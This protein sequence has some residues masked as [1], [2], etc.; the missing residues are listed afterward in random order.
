MADKL[1]LVLDTL[2]RNFRFTQWPKAAV[3][4]PFREAALIVDRFFE[5]KATI[6]AD[7][8][9]TREGKVAARAQ[10]GQVA[11]E[12]INKWHTPRVAGL[13]ADLGVHRAALLP[14]S[15]EKPDA[16]RIDFLLS[17]LRDRTPQEIATFYN[18]ATD[19]ERL[20][21]EAAAASV[22]RIPMKSANGL[23]WT[24]LLDPETV[25]GSI[26]ARATAKN[27]AGAKKL[28]ELTEI[29]AMHVTVAGIATA[30]VRAALT[31]G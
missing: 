25:N 15:T 17:H 5:Q 26:I 14:A 30:E 1:R 12:A 23:V 7:R 29:R 31:E 6:D 8:N 13:D 19:E 16:R 4:D 18:S 2:D 11:M 24:S 27:P 10:A 9:L 28:E 20:V 22:G 21:M 3:L